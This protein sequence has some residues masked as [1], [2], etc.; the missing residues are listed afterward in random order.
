MNQFNLYVGK[1]LYK[2]TN[3]RQDAEYTFKKWKRNGAN[4]TMRVVSV[5]LIEKVAA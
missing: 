3:C 2:T 5:V 1:L 4:V